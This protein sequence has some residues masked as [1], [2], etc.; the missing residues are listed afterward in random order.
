MIARRYRRMMRGHAEALMPMIVETMAEA[1]ESFRLLDAVAVTVGPGAFTGIRVGLAAARGIALAAGIPAVGVTTFAAV[2][3]SVPESERGNRRLVVLLDSRR[4]DVFVQEFATSLRPA[5]PPEI[6]APASFADDLA[7]E[8]TILAGDGVA[9]VRPH[10]TGAK[11]D[12]EFSSMDGPTDAAH[13]AVA[14]IRLL[15]SGEALPARPLYLRAP[16]VRPADRE[17]SAPD[18]IGPRRP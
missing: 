14:A 10:L 18:K 6:R 15:A 4:G 8:R 9:L 11:L 1:G 17:A 13:V 7:P 16:D 3:E 5:R 12:V 2:A